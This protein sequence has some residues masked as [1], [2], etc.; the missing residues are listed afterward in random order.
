MGSLR[1]S[2][3]PL[4]SFIL[5]AGAAKIPPSKPVILKSL[6]PSLESTSS[7]FHNMEQLSFFSAGL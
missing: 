7:D 3:K 2:L 1:R 6:C 4:T 5:Q